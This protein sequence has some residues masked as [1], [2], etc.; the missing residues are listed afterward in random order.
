VVVVTV[1][2]A[3]GP[4]STVKKAVISRRGHSHPVTLNGMELLIGLF[5]RFLFIVFM[6]RSSLF[7]LPAVLKIIG[8]GHDQLLSI[9]YNF[10]TVIVTVDYKIAT[11]I[12]PNAIT[13]PNQQIRHNPNDLKSKGF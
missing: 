12:A 3:T 1:Q 13:M 10:A 6:I 9:D 11:I 8:P 7:C 5:L 2:A 4:G